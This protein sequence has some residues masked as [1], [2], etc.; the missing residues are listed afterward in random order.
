MFYV[1]F[2]FLFSIFAPDNRINQHNTMKYFSRLNNQVGWGVFVLSTAVYLLT[3]EPTASFWDCG[4]FIAAS[5]KLQVP[6]PPG[7]PFFL[8]VNRMFSMLAFGNVESVAFWV[9]VS[10]ALFSGF[11]ILFLFWT[12]TLLGLKFY[13]TEE[14]L[15]QSQSILLVGAGAIGALAYAFSDS[16][17][18]SA[19]EAEVYAMS[20]FFTALVFWEML[21]W[22]R[23]EDE[24]R[25]NKWLLLIAYTI[26]LSIGVHLLNLVAIP[27]LGLIYYYKK[28]P[29][30]TNQGTLVTLVISGAL[31]LVIMLG[32][33]PGLP[34]W[35][36][37][38]EVFF[39]NSLGMPFGTG[40][41]LFVSLL[42][43]SL[44][45]G[46]IYSIRQGKVLLNTVFMSLAFIL[47]GYAS[48]GIVLVRSQYNPPIDENNPENIVSFVSYLKREQ[49]G[50]RPLFYGQKFTAKLIDQY[51]G[52]PVY[53]KDNQLKKYVVQDHR[54]V[55]VYDKN[56]LLPRMYSRDPEHQRL[57]R[58]I[59]ELGPQQ[60]PSM[61]DNIGFLI[62]YQLIHMYWRYFGWNFVGREHDVQNAG[63]LAPWESKTGNVPELIGQNKARNQY[64]A[65]P[66]IL[67][68]LGFF[69]NYLR[70]QKVFLIVGLLFFLT[71]IALILYLNS[72]PVEPRERDYIYVGS[73]YA[74][75]IWIGFGVMALGELLERVIANKVV[76]T[77]LACTLSL[78]VPGIMIA[79]NW[80]D[81]DRSQ[82]YFSVDS[83]KNLLNSCAPNAILF[84]GGD[85]DTFP[86]WYVQE[87]EGFRTDVR[88][89]NLSLLATDW[90]IEQMKRQAYESAP[91]PI[92]LEEPQFRQGVNDQ[93]VYTPYPYVASEAQAQ[94]I[95]AQGIDLREYFNYLKNN[96]SAI[97]V[98]YT[99]D[100]SL[101]FIPS[102]RLRLK[103]DKD[104]VKALG[105]VPAEYEDRI[106]G[107]MDWTLSKGDL[108]K[109]DLMILDMIAHN[110]WERPI[111]FS[112]TLGNSSYLNL[113][114]YFQQEGLALRLLPAKLGSRN[115]RGNTEIFVN[116]DL[117]YQNM[118]E[119]QSININ[120]KAFEKQMYWRNL[121]KPGVYY[122]ENY[123][124]FTLNSRGSFAK[125]V[126][127]LI[128]E[129]KKD[130][131]KEA[132]LYC[133]QKIP[134]SPIAYDVYSVQF[135]ALALE[136]DLKEEAKEIADK[137]GRR[138]VEMLD[139][140]TKKGR[141]DDREIT[142][143]LIILSQIEAAMRNYEMP[144]A[145]Q[146]K[147]MLEK[148]ERSFRD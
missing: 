43:G 120:G 17:W 59:A 18:F 96:P 42:L 134:D 30:T 135:V 44:L 60:E 142:T 16:F 76:S 94:Q 81:H 69:Y 7:A 101:T 40:I 123:Q 77:A 82:R 108:F 129:E 3:L 31:I 97:R 24:Q 103:V 23:V 143:N 105:I 64:F 121:D 115:Q 6:H 91:L 65:L 2:L 37:N 38:F 147:K 13:K 116:S 67:G 41:T 4:E 138:A 35:A 146:Y 51:K 140:L 57:Y 70:Q 89:C 148:Y 68:L 133:M 106:V 131:A 36:G 98:A 124:R 144:E 34:S 8:L 25:A 9:N 71:G 107:E 10:S 33:I 55:N 27:A 46:I 113:Q 92:S 110:N 90:Y 139:Y 79:E 83:A 125:L 48:Y 75:A 14:N 1:G 119:K 15:S 56:T 141:Y 73:F 127:Q 117:M 85:N 52:A 21:K 128:L 29:N 99:K 95:D 66:L 47:I 78:L 49:Y 84:T 104:K 12:I 86:L 111:Y 88:V 20:S 39:T 112:S 26:G 74:F 32:V 61:G 114:E 5:Y 19:V 130:K 93:I 72:P 137:M 45:Y 145:E 53:R 132:L 11:T 126:E 22:E 118:V 54:L 58:Q 100:D 136:L 80:D 50:D 28:Y 109:S 87:V 102:K 122:D 62:K 63:T